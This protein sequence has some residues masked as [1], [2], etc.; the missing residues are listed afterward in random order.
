MRCAAPRRQPPR[1]AEAGVGSMKAEIE[2]ELAAAHARFARAAMSIYLGTA[3]VALLLL[4]AARASGPSHLYVATPIRRNGQFTGALLGAI[5]PSS[6]LDR[7]AGRALALATMDGRVIYPPGPPPVDTRPVWEAVG[8]RAAEPF[9]V[10][11]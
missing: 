10:E 1:R 9:A 2:T 7:R 11:A 5:D 3:A 4:L 8:R 6:L